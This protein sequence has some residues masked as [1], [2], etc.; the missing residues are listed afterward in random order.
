MPTRIETNENQNKILIAARRLI[1]TVCNGIFVRNVR[2]SR[3]IAGRCMRTKVISNETEAE[4]TIN[5]KGTLHTM[6][7]KSSVIHELA[8]NVTL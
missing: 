3:R 7:T 8:P 6:M 1:K 2:H 5:P 4:A